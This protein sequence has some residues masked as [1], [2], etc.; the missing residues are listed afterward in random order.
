MVRFRP[1]GPW[2]M[3]PDS[4]ARNRVDRIYHSDS[5][6]SA[7]T[8]A[9]ARLGRLEEWLAATA[10]NPQGAAVR[11]SS[12]FPFLE[13]LH[14][15]V[16]PRN[17]WPPPPS[18]KVR[19]G[20]AR[21][22]PLPVVEALANE[23]PLKDSAWRLDGA[24]EC[25]LPANAPFH[26]G[27]FRPVVRSY[28]GVD[29]KSGAAV[30][31]HDRACLEFAPGGGMWAIASFADQEAEAR[32]KEAVRAAMRLLADSGLGG[33]RSMGWGHSAE[34]E[35]FEC[36]LPETIL[37]AKPA[38]L[39]VETPEGA[40]AAPK[41]P[42]EMGYWLLSMFSPGSGDT[43]DWQRGC[44]SMATRGGRIESPAR[45]GEAKKLLRMVEEGSV[46]VA[47]APPQG[48]APNVAPDGFPHPV[49]RAGFAVAIPVP[50]RPA[51]RAPGAA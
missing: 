10:Q 37:P 7:V 41:A 16:P 14:F 26:D 42:A 51:E 4:G 38:A 29:R 46:L 35:F 12:C 8:H 28:A 1:A 19:W 48:A 22:V 25:L 18:A 36:A 21:F 15:V 20:N 39:P 34:P 43:V 11:F 6:F 47:D 23:R 5:L 33:G 45:S 13:D 30:A 3:G 9:L 44:Y 40:E 27:P 49:Y 24:S 50:L 32:W 17:L 2:R 31:A